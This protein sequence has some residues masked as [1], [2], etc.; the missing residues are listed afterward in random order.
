MESGREELRRI[1][2]IRPPSHTEESELSLFKAK[3]IQQ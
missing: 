2:G 1:P 3:N